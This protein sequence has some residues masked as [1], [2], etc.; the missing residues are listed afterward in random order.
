M[1]YIIAL[2]VGL[3][4]GAPSVLNAIQILDEQSRSSFLFC[5]KYDRNLL[6]IDRDDRGR[7]I[8]VDDNGISIALSDIGAIDIERWSPYATDRDHDGDTYL[9]RIYRVMLGNSSR[10][11]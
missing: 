9:N 11:T 3:L 6:Y 8:S 5:L 7:Y 2:V 10:F 1:I 4:F